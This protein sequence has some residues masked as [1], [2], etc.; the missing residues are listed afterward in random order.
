M[1]EAKEKRNILHV[2]VDE[3]DGSSSVV[4]IDCTDADTNTKLYDLV[5]R[6]LAQTHPGKDMDGLELSY[7]VLAD[8]QKARVD[9]RLDASTVIV[10]EYKKKQKPRRRR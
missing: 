4:H 7:A 5:R 10:N 1:A 3:D 6:V 2:V 9:R 8:P